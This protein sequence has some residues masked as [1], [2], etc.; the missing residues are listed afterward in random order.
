MT[1]IVFMGEPMAELLRDRRGWA[2][3]YSGDIL[4]AAVAAKISGLDNA[5]L[6]SAIGDDPFS[7]EFREFL[8]KAQI[9]TRFVKAVPGAELGLYSASF[10]ASG[11]ATF[12]YWRR[13]A[14]ARLTLQLVSRR[15]FGNGAASRSTLPA[16]S[17]RGFHRMTARNC[18]LG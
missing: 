18:L 11:E 8:A 5:V 9:D 17:S 15:E 7:G 13:D 3:R 10:D 14:P 4:N 1:S 16:F 2:V 12:R 6:V